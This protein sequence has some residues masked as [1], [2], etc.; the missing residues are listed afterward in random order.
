M[1]AFVFN[2]LALVFVLVKLLKICDCVFVHFST[3]KILSDQSC[4]YIAT[5]LNL[6]YSLRSWSVTLYEKGLQN[7]SVD[8]IQ[9]GKKS[10]ILHEQHWAP[11]PYWV[12]LSHFSADFQMC[13]VYQQLFKSTVTLTMIFCVNRTKWKLLKIVSW[14][15]L[16]PHTNCPPPYQTRPPPPPTPP[17]AARWQSTPIT[18]HQH[19]Q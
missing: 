12:I 14:P 11:S 13:Q 6:Y 8:R 3:A 19:H 2:L 17:T 15:S 9:Q 18:S 16:G 10:N 5:N 1:I 4:L 7:T